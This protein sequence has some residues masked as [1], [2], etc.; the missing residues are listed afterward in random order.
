MTPHAENTFLLAQNMY[1]SKIA[2][3][4]YTGK[5]DLGEKVKHNWPSGA[6]STE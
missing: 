3:E 4:E 2:Q 6:A 1:S 5:Y